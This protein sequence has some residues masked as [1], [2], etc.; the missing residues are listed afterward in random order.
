MG[1]YINSC[2][3]KTNDEKHYIYKI[4]TYE[5]WLVVKKKGYNYM[6]SIDN[7]DKIE[8]CYFN[9][10]SKFSSD[11]INKSNKSVQ[12]NKKINNKS[13]VI[14]F[15]VKKLYNN[16]YIV[17]EIINNK[18]NEKYPYIYVVKDNIVIPPS[19]ITKK[20]YI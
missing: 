1:N 9:Q 15:S 13:V 18:T 6:F 19:C 11:F 3:N 14:S 7:I 10:I 8:C 5:E 17:R 12:L 2:I 4:I 16:G 20:M